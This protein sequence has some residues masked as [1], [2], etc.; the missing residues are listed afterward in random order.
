VI[1]KV[2]RRTKKTTDAKERSRRKFKFERVPVGETSGESLDWINEVVQRLWPQFNTAICKKIEE[3]LTPILKENVPVIHRGLSIEHFT[4]GN[5]PPKLDH[6]KIYRRTHG[7]EMRL[8]VDFE[9]EADI[10]MNAVMLRI[11]I[12]SVCFKGILSVRFKP[13]LSEFPVIGGMVISFLN[14]PRV[15]LNFHVSLV[16]EASFLT[17]IIEHSIESAIANAMVYPNVIPISVAGETLTDAKRSI[18]ASPE[19]VGVLRVTCISG[20]GSLVLIGIF[21]VRQRVT[22]M[23]P[24]ELVLILGDVQLKKPH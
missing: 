7:V 5:V 21:S 8:H 9:S 19:P 14:P 23:C 17:Q 15:S 4:L 1:G 10:W 12:K 3:A 20:E 24:S 11:G 2:V 13:L 22:H 6:M 16:Q 18:L